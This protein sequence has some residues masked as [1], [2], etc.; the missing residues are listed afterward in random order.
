VFEMLY[1][2]NFVPRCKQDSNALPNVSIV[3]TKQASHCQ[4]L[5][6]PYCTLRIKGWRQAR[7]DCDKYG[8]G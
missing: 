7:K 5:V 3:L 8:R 1:V 2:E 4:T 6:S